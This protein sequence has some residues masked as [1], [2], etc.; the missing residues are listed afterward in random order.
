[1]SPDAGL[2]AAALE[3]PRA[4]GLSLVAARC[5]TVPEDFEVEEQLGFA[6]SGQ[7]AHLLLRV[8]KVG[9]NTA[10]VARELARAA[11]CRPHD[12]GYAGLKD[13]NAVALQWFSVPRPRAPLELAGLRGEGF[14]VLEAH[15]HARKLPRGALAGNHFRIRLRGAGAAEELAAA[16][17]PGIEAIARRGVPNYFGPQRFGRDGANLDRI[18]EDPR[19]LAAPERGFV[20][21][22]A[23]S[24]V[25]N[26]LLG[27]R[28]HDGSWERLGA[29]DL[30]VLDGRGS[31]FAVED[32]ADPGLAERCARL[33]IHPSGPLWGAGPSPAAAAVAQRE[34]AVA[35]GLAR[36]CRAC[37]LAGMRQE[38]RALRLRVAAL[39]LAAQADAV[40]ISFQLTR[41][42]FATAVLRELVGGA[43]L[44]GGES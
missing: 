5:R 10:W 37:E 33:E 42:S 2:R 39:A 11:R 9:A 38:R 29:G 6:P 36:A 22:A 14:E 16:L 27:A 25:F 1:M 28:V 30:A 15:A 7:G 24:A 4:L 40:L 41:G 43:E 21:S 3:P 20:L 19:S 35:A 23:R 8:R 32:A 12:V 13:R 17:R 44:P 31:F 26:A 18:P 34:A